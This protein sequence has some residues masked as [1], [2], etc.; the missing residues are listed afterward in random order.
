MLKHDH[1]YIINGD[2][3]ISDSGVY[4]AAGAIFDYRRIDDAIETSDENSEGVTEW[5]TATGPIRESVHLMVRI[6][7]IQH[8]SPYDSKKVG[9]L[10]SILFYFIRFS[11]KAK[12]PESNMN[13]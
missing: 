12:I 7:D 5:I 6:R 4:R 1:S 10:C 2:N 3:S 11:V 9:W 8:F 13:T